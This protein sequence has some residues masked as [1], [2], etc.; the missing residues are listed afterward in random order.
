MMKM[1]QLRIL[2]RR[3]E[4][5]RQEPQLTVRNTREES[6]S[7]E[8]LGKQEE[9]VPISTGNAVTSIFPGVPNMRKV[10]RKLTAS[11]FIQNSARN[12]LIWNV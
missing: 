7:L 2:L 10:V 8:C 6:V 3:K 5:N 4:N 9:L 12:L 11:F 1:W